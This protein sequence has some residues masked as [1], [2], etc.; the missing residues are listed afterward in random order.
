MCFIIVYT[1]LRSGTTYHKC[2]YTVSHHYSWYSVFYDRQEEEFEETKG[3]IRI[4]KSKDNVDWLLSHW[5]RYHR[6]YCQQLC[7]N[8]CSQMMVIVES[9][10]YKISMGGMLKNL[11][12]FNTLSTQMGVVKCYCF[13]WRRL[14][15]LETH[16]TCIRAKSHNE[17]PNK[18]Q[19]TSMIML[20]SI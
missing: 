5:H 19:V 13:T 14:C 7:F 2:T 1:G 12:P 15:S 11:I 20:N 10:A 18:P 6:F 8:N 9:I 16:V 17:L 3:V 4:C